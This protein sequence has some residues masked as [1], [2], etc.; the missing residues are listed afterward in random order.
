M[1]DMSPVA[2]VQAYNSALLAAMAAG[3]REAVIAAVGPYL[4]PDAT[5]RE[6]SGLPWGGLYHGGGT[7]IGDLF[8]AGSLALQAFHSNWGA[9]VQA[10]ALAD[11]E[12][13]S[14]GRVVTR[15]AWMTFPATV[16]HDALSVPLIDRYL[17][18]DGLIT[19]IEVYF[20][21]VPEMID[22]FDFVS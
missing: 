19:E 9:P 6:S 3:S 13:L 11:D 7:G 14:D 1:S 18:T 22:R 5:C 15:R 12:Y 8:E 16:R 21:D 20:F 4:H 2:V 17:I 10:S